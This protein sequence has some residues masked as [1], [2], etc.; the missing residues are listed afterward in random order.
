[1]RKY[2]YKTCLQN[3]SSFLKNSSVGSISASNII[4]L[5]LPIRIFFVEVS[6]EDPLN[7][8]HPTDSIIMPLSKKKR[9]KMIFI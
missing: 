6:D 1:M 2:I 5:R 8:F 3:F 4:P 9:E 7:L